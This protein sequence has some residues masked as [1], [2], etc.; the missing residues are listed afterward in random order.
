MADQSAEHPIDRMTKSISAWA[1]CDSMVQLDAVRLRSV[2]ADDAASSG[3]ILTEIECEAFVCGAENG[4][5]PQALIDA[6]PKT[7]AYLNE[8]WA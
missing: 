1:F 4:E 6:Y 3:R 8:F 7:H 5:V 2:L